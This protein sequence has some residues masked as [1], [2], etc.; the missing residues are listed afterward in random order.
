MNQRTRTEESSA[1][2]L[3]VRGTEAAVRTLNEQTYRHRPGH[4]L[5]ARASERGALKGEVQTIPL[6]ARDI[7]EVS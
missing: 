5:V 6:R 2:D 3:A 4:E 7:A 1:A